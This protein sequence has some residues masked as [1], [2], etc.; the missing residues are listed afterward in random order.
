LSSP[1]KTKEAPSPGGRWVAVA[2]IA[3]EFPGLQVSLSA[4]VT[5][6]G[7]AWGVCQLA[8]ARTLGR[9][10]VVGLPV[11]RLDQRHRGALVARNEPGPGGRHPGRTLEAH[12]SRIPHQRLG[13]R[14][15]G[16]AREETLAVLGF[17]VARVV[18]PLGLVLGMGAVIARKLKRTGSS[19]AGKAAV[20][21]S[22]QRLN[23]RRRG[24]PARRLAAS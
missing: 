17:Q 7:V 24:L 12:L 19:H 2:E 18:P 22:L 5:K 3:R 9:T 21:G 1:K 10:P 11:Q 14:P 4:E 16:V 13:R 20:G 15:D 8:C 6:V 23:R